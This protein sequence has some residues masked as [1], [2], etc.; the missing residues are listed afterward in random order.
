MSGSAVVTIERRVPPII[1]KL[2]RGREPQLLEQ[3]GRLAVQDE[4]GGQ[5]SAL[6]AAERAWFAKR[7]REGLTRTRGVLK[8]IKND[9]LDGD[10]DDLE[11]L[12]Q[13]A[14]LRAVMEALPGDVFRS[15]F[16]D[17]EW[18]ELE[19]SEASIASERQ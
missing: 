6:V 2:K 9:A 17:E 5:E 14:S 19:A 10:D 13:L 15:L 1:L 16:G 4:G 11:R 3:G 12:V 18:Q 7:L 8:A